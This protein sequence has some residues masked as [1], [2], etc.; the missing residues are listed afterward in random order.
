MRAGLIL[1]VLFLFL[2][3]IA[4]AHAA[5][6]PEEYKRIA[7][8]ALRLREIARVVA[9]EPEHSPKT[10]RTTIVAE[11][12]EVFT[13]SRARAKV[14]DTIVI[15]YTVDLAALKK[16]LDKFKA[17]PPRPGPQFLHEPDPP[18]LNDDREFLAYLAPAS[19]RLANVNRYA[20]A[21]VDF[22]V[23]HFS[24]PV[25]VPVAAQYSFEL[26]RSPLPSEP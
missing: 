1:A 10:R 24:G 18:K 19:T 22:T 25:F 11:V 15:D 4:A 12:L 14:G 16:R 17:L 21:K 7:S 23:A 13:P 2:G 6:N 5:I 9:S 20:G 26:P 8:D 3:S